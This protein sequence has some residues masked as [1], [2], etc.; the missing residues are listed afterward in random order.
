DY[1]NASLQ[2]HPSHSGLAFIQATIRRASSFWINAE[3][4][5]SVEQSHS[6]VE[7]G[8]RGRAAG[9][10]NGDLASGAEEPPF[11]PSSQPG[12]GEVFPLGQEREPAAD[13]QR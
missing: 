10:V 9:T 11:E 12:G 7:G 6:R 2:R 8:L 1:R 13:H 3:Q 4:F 5:T